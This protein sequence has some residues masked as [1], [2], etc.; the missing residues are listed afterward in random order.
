MKSANGTGLLTARRARSEQC[1][2]WLRS[3]GKDSHCKSSEEKSS[4]V[5]GSGVPESSSE[6][7]H[8]HF[9]CHNHCPL[10]ART[11]LG[12]P[13]S[14][15]RVARARGNKR[16]SQ[17]KLTHNPFQPGRSELL[18][19]TGNSDLDEVHE[20]IPSAIEAVPYSKLQAV[21]V[22]PRLRLL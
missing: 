21:R 17:I 18:E 11:E 9:L 7:F 19:P 14:L 3:I 4:H 12:A 1:R 6:S 16:Y 22:P 10:P 2:I 8:G 13:G 15:C 5:L 20:V